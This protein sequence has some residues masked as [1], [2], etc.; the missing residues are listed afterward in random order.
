MKYGP[1][2]NDG[3]SCKIAVPTALPSHMRGRVVELRS[4]RTIP[5]KRGQ[6]HAADLMLGICIEADMSRTFLF[7]AVEPD[8]DGP[9]DTHSLSQF[10]M[11]FGFL[12]IQSDPPLMARPYV[13]ALMGQQA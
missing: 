12:P 10:Y 7:L 5:D 4:L 11:K 2:T 8:D 13:G 6:G 1:R 3:A 9:L